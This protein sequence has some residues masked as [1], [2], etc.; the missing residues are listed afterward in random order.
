VLDEAAS[1]LD[2]ENE[3]MVQQALEEL[4]KDKT[5]FIIAHRFSTLSIVNRILVFEKGLV[6]GDGTHEKLE[7]SCELYRDLRKRQKFD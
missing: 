2:S 1:A 4:T 3:A 5:V 6:V 7:Q